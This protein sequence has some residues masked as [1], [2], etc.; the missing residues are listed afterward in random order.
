MTENRVLT[1]TGPPFAG[2]CWPRSPA[3]LTLPVHGRQSVAVALVIPSH[4][5]PGDDY[6]DPEQLRQLECFD[7]R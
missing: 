7:E 1:G 6:H 4:V 3:L 2:S 5:V